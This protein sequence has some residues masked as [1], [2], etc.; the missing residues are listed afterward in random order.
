MRKY[1]A[2]GLIALLAIIAIGSCDL[3][4]KQE[5]KSTEFIPLAIKTPIPDTL[6]LDTLRKSAAIRLHLRCSVEHSNLW[7]NLHF[8]HSSYGDTIFHYGASA[9]L[10]YEGQD[11]NGIPI[12]ADTT[13]VMEYRVPQN[14]TVDYTFH[15]KLYIHTISPQNSRIDTLLLLHPKHNKK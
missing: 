15:Q 13:F 4:G 2:A 12:T 14:K 9:R 1:I 3:N 7:T 5:I 8:M 6:L 10:Y 11:G